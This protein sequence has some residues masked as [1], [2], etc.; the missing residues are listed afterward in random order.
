MLLS[1]YLG[2]EVLPFLVVGLGDGWAEKYL[3]FTDDLGIV[4]L[5]DHGEAA[6]S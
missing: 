2:E 5:V 3:C 4:R 1:I 6:F